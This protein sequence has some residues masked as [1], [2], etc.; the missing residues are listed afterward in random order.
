MEKEEWA[1]DEG[2]IETIRLRGL[3]VVSWMARRETI[4][5]DLVSITKAFGRLGFEHID[6]LILG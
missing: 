2:D 6:F 1:G 5:K 4:M 3:W